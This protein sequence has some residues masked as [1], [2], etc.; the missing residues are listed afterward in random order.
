MRFSPTNAVEDSRL[1]PCLP[2]HRAVLPTKD[3]REYIEELIWYPSIL[4]IFAPV[5]RRMPRNSRQQRP[6]TGKQ[7]LSSNA[8][9]ANTAAIP[10]YPQVRVNSTSPTASP[11]NAHL[12]NSGTTVL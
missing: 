8:A 6:Q 1:C 11:D 12:G 7:S 10:A 5:C 2:H 9:I 3:E 4:P